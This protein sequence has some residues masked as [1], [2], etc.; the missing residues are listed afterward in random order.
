VALATIVGSSKSRG[1]KLLL[2]LLFFEYIF[3]ELHEHKVKPLGQNKERA[4]RDNKRKREGRES[5][6]QAGR[7]SANKRTHTKEKLRDLDESIRTLKK[8][9]KGRDALFSAKQDREREER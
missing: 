6:K 2:L 5:A 9:N 1:G 3:N 4:R 8:T 7:Q